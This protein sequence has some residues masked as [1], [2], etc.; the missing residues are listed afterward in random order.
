MRKLILILTAIAT[1]FSCNEKEEANPILDGTEWICIKES[2][3][4][5]MEYTLSFTATSISAD[6]ETES[7]IFSYAY[8]GKYVKG[9]YDRTGVH[10][11]IKID[12]QYCDE[13]GEF[14]EDYYPVR[15]YR[16]YCEDNNRPLALYFFWNHQKEESQ[17]TYSRVKK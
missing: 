14:T 8:N 13:N 1:L 4:Q 10:S 3:G 11:K 2:R 5:S 16:C 7:G 6:S 12:D 15:I 9:T 17:R